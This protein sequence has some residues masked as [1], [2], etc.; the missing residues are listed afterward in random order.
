MLDL[1]RARGFGRRWTNWIAGLL[2]AVSTKIG[3]NGDL[4]DTICHHRGLRQGDPLSLLLFVIVMDSHAG[5]MEAA[6]RVQ[7]LQSIGMIR[8]PYRISMYVDDV[9]LFINPSRSEMHAAVTLLDFFQSV[10]G[11]WM[12][13][14]KSAATPIT[15]TEELAEEAVVEMACLTK[16]FP[17]TYLG[18]PLSDARLR[19]EDLQ[20]ILDCLAKRLRG[21]KAKLIVLPGRIELVKTVLSAMAIYLIM[22][23]AP[24]I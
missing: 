8:M 2:A 24:P 23:I 13:W 1:L 9:V 15:C 7:V 19:R 11:L 18:L 12:N 4:S 17:I 21:W 14:A 3:I 5:L 16:V 10:S 20:P 6:S 22:A